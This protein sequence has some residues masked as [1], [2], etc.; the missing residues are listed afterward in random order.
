MSLFDIFSTQPAQNAANA[1][2]AGLNAG[3][4]TASGN[5]QQAIQALQQNY[6]TATNQ[7]TSNYQSSLLPWM[8]NYNTA[9]GGVTAL[10]N[11][12]G[13]NGPS[14]TQSALQTV[15]NSP[16][17]QFQQQSGDAAINAAAAANGTAGSGNQL[18]ALSNYNQQLAGGAFN[19]YVNQLQPFLGQSNTAASGISS[20]YQG[21]GSG[22]AG[23][24]TGLGSSLAGQYGDLANLGWQTQTGIGNANANA[25]LSAYNASGNMLGALMGILGGGAKAG[26][27]S[28]GGGLGSS[29]GSLLSGAGSGAGSLLSGLGSGLGSIL[30]VFSDERLKDDIKK[31]G[32]LYD[33]TNVYRYRYL[34]DDPAMTRIGVMAQEVEKTRPDAIGEVAGFKTVDYGAATDLASQLGKFIEADN[35]NS[36]NGDSFVSSLAKFMDAA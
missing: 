18:L 34:W 29:I 12:L 5:I 13:L 15:Q 22:L 4:N 17:Y 21:L 7:L 14:G 28:S 1:Q 10:T 16:G 2:I 11:A 36:T 24:S 19:N 33:G 6:G 3:Y 26:A 27:S 9:Q 32:E 23:L 35:D 25:D 30:G 8:Q 31:V 20:G